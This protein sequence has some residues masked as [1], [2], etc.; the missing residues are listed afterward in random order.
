MNESSSEK[1]IVVPKDPE[2]VLYKFIHEFLKKLVGGCIVYQKVY[3]RE[4]KK[5][6]SLQRFANVV[7]ISYMILFLIGAFTNIASE[8]LIFVNVGYVFI[9]SAF[10][11]KFR[12]F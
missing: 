8:I 1:N 3:K 6:T 10:L 2:K 7:F 5:I 12:F 11:I 4:L 9:F